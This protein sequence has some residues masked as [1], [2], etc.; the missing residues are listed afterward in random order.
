MVNAYLLCASTIVI[1]GLFYGLISAFIEDRVNVMAF[2]MEFDMHGRELITRSYMI[3]IH[4][5]T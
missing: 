2:V 3:L 4:S 1:I 5:A